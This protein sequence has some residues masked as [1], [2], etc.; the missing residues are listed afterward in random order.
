MVSCRLVHEGRAGEELASSAA[1]TT[2]CALQERRKPRAFRR[3]RAGRR[4]SVD[5]EL[6]ELV[7]QGT[8]GDAQGGGLGLVVAV[9]LQGLLDGGAFDFLDV[10]SDE[11]RVGKECVSTCRARWLPYD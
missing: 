4:N 11:R 6:L 5:P 2:A 10:R 3:R 8:E 9:F 1:P 7:P